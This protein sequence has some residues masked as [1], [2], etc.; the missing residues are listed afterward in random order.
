MDANRLMEFLTHEGFRP[1]LAG[2]GDVRFKYEGGNYAVRWYA[3][4][5]HFVAV[6]YP[7]FWRV[8]SDEELARCYRAASRAAEGTKIAKVV[9]L[10][11][12][13]AWAVAELLVE[14]FE[15]FQ[16]FFPRTLSILKYAV[17]RFADVMRQS[18][19]V[20]DRRLELRR[21][22]ITRFTHEN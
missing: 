5:E 22:D 14:R 8:Q 3:D 15:Q 4:D 11:D 13:D 17:N 16:A 1:T 20:P 2:P 21:G 6:V 12:R 19:P 9:V 7:N 18:E 10:E